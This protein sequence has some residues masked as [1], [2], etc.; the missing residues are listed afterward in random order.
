[1]DAREVILTAI[2]SIKSIDG[3]NTKTM[4]WAH[5]RYNGVLMRDVE[6]DKLS[7]E[8]LVEVYTTIVR[9]CSMQM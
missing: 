5:T 1:M 2:E 9:R 3:F 6:F 7:D 8:D 4:R